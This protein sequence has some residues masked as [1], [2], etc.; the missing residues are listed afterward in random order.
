MSTALELMYSADILSAE[1]A[2]S[3]RLVRSIHEPDDLLPSAYALAHKFIDG[4]SSA[5]L[6]MTRRLRYCDAGS[7]HPLEA[8]RRD[9]LAMCTSQ[10]ATAGK[11]T[12]RPW[13]V[14]AVHLVRRRNSRSRPIRGGK[15]ALRWLLSESLSGLPQYQGGIVV[16]KQVIEQPGR[17]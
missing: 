17:G 14:T 9:S 6:A 16:R 7:T 8:H 1:E 4:R 2:L 12:S 11:R 10:S 5:A 13:A 15:S 3:H